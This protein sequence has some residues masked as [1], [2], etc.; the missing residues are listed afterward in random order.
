MSKPITILAAAILTIGLWDNWTMG[1]EG[2]NGGT[3]EE[4]GV[5]SEGRGEK[6]SPAIANR[7]SQST[8]PTG[9]YEPGH[10]DADADGFVWEKKAKSEKQASSIEQPA[11]D[12]ESRITN[13]APIKKQKTK[14]ENSA[15]LSGFLDDQ[16]GEEKLEARQPASLGSAFLRMLGG[17]GVVA[18]I[19][20]LG[21]TLL[22]KVSSGGNFLGKRGKLWNV[23]ECTALGPKRH[24]YVTRFVDRILLIGATDQQVTI[25][26]EIKDPAMVAAIESGDADFRRFMVPESLSG[27]Q[28]PSSVE[29][30]EAG[31]EVPSPTP[32]VPEIPEIPKP[33]NGGDIPPPPTTFRRSFTV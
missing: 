26:S 20:I 10:P 15:Y 30:Q 1:E 9:R 7:Q 16:R 27:L 24:L 2:K 13:Q 33:E 4:R 28:N 18:G 8:N 19:I 21:S 25:L 11:S 12:H 22:K 31:T 6:G 17:L 14:I 5:K 3:G 23:V 32:Q 29:T